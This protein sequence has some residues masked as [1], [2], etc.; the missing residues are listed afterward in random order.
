MLKSSLGDSVRRPGFV[1]RTTVGS[2]IVS[3]MCS[4]ATGE[5]LEVM[6]FLTLSLHPTAFKACTCEVTNRD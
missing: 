1:A 2:M 4:S 6:I 5:H 3:Y